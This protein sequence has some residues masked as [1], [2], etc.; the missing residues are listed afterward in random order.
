VNVV[1]QAILASAAS[2]HAKAWSIVGSRLDVKSRRKSGW[3]L[4]IL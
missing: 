3:G 1:W 4:E 2:I